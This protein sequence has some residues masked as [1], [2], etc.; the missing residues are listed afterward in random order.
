[1][2]TEEVNEEVEALAAILEEDTV[3]VVREEGEDRPKVGLSFIM[4]ELD[5]TRL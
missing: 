1:M 2:S 4:G 5:T 3:E